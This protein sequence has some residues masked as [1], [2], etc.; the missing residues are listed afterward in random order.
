MYEYAPCPRCEYENPLE[1]R[2]CGRCGASLM[3]GGQLA[4]RREENI[5]APAR[6][7]LPAR[8]G[9]VGKALAVGLTALA[10]EATLAWLRRQ[11]ERPDRPALPATQDPKPVVPKYLVGRSL[12]EV[13]VW[14]QEED[15]GG[16]GFAWRTVRT[17][18]I[19]RP[20]DRHG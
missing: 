9:P 17:F 3:A 14:L 20:T 7:A 19:T 6:S 2:F 16:R 1:N 10:A 15:L 11:V 13:S 5:P 4:P 8:L 12:E 18:G